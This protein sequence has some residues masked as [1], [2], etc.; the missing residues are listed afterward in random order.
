MLLLDPDLSPP[1][2][3]PSTRAGSPTLSHVPVTV[4]DLRPAEEFERA[5]VR[6]AR[7]I[8][9]PRTKEDFYGDSEAIETRWKE[10][11]KVFAKDEWVWSGEGPALVICGDGDTG[12]MGAAMLR[13]RGREGFC[14]EGGYDALV[15]GGFVDGCEGL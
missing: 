9:L 10:L 8:P 7:S 2:S 6:G 1:S 14:V 5:H 4:L 11:K 12:K 3:G 15:A 13:A